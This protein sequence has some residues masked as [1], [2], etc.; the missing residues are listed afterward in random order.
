ME[1][2]GQEVGCGDEDGTVEE[3]YEQGGDVGTVAK[4]SRR[5][6]RRHGD[7]T[8]DNGEEEERQEAKCDEADDNGRSPGAGNTT[9]EKTEKEHQG[10]TD[11]R[12]SAKP[13]NCSQS[14]PD[15]RFG[16]VQIK[17]GH[18]DDE[19]HS[20]EWYYMENVSICVLAPFMAKANSRGHL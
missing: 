1:V 19:C 9:K 2:Q 12:Q 10:A 5:H 6:D 4:D 20:V 7:G 11:N 14:G 13:V 3:A 16:S 8:L 15:R 18:D 17:E